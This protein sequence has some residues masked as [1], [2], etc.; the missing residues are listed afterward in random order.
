MTEIYSGWQQL[1]WKFT[2]LSRSKGS[3]F[4]TIVEL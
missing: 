3:G 1:G 4:T 2:G